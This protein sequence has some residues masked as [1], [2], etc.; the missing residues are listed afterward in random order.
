MKLIVVGSTGFVATEV[1]RQTLSNPAITSIVGV[2]RRKVPV[3]ENTWPD[4]DPAKFKS[5]VMDDWE[6][7]SES[8]KKELSNADACIWYSP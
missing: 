3:P 6:N 5:I 4:A 8:V 7:Y 1:I 2:G